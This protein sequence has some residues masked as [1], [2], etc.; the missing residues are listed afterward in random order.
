ML[1]NESHID[2]RACELQLQRVWLFVGLL[3]TF[4]RSTQK[5]AHDWNMFRRKETK[6]KDGGCFE[7]HYGHQIESLRE[8]NSQGNNTALEN[9]ADI[10]A[11]GWNTERH[12][13]QPIGKWN[14]SVPSPLN[15]P[16]R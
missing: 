7:K 2:I 14:P 1:I 16:K 13:L 6:E 10:Y 12:I 4:L 3:V 8:L 9:E 11:E 5:S 15:L